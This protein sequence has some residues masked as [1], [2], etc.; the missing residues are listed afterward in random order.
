MWIVSPART[1]CFSPRKVASSSPSD[2][3]VGLLH[4]QE[5]IRGAIQARAGAQNPGVLLMGAGGGG[6][7][8]LGGCLIG[9]RGSSVQVR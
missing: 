6:S 4:R 7:G 3:G 8:D 2:A 1:I 9:S 5:D